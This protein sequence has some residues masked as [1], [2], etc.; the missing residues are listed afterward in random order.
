MAAGKSEPRD[1]DREWLERVF[2]HHPPED[3]LAVH[4]Y[5]VVR[6]AG[7]ALADLIMKTCPDTGDRSTALLKVREAVMWANASIACKEG[8]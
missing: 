4:R 3:A 6:G 2:T 7:F 1:P 5:Q 8:D